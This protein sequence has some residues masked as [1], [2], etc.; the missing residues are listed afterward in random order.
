MPERKLKVGATVKT[1][2]VPAYAVYQ[3]G[4]QIKAKIPP[5]PKVGVKSVAGHT[6][7]KDAPDDSPEMQ[8]YREQLAVLDAQLESLR[9]DFTNDYSIESWSWDGGVTWQIDP[10]ASWQ[11]PETLKRYGFR[12]GAN[13]RADYIRYELLVH[14]D[15]MLLV[16]QDALGMSA[17]I[18]NTEVDAALGGFRGQVQGRR[19]ARGRGK[20]KR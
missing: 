11:F 19:I 5:L 13:R 18:G 16:Q 2:L 15:D 6:E 8:A 1:R 3:V 7:Y 12:E 10:P 17:P 20:S 4:L 9:S 14:N